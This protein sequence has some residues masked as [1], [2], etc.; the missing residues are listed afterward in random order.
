M[1]KRP[2][3]A[4]SETFSVVVIAL[5]VAL[6]AILLVAS[7]TGVITNLLVKPATFSV[8]AVQYTT[9]S[10]AHIIGLFHQQGDEV[11]LS[12]TS[13]TGGVSAVS[14]TL[15]DPAGD[16]FAVSNA[17]PLHNDDWEPGNLL[18]IYKSGSAY[19]YS[20]IAPGSGVGTLSAG[21]YTVKITDEKAKVLLHT[22]PITIQ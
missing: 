18:Y 6:A 10:G 12:G 4:L 7:L 17:G 8:E 22:L 5:L 3:Y 19:E 15:V 21:T 20:D 11:R 13:Q 14:I 16:T 1:M 9:S 2:D